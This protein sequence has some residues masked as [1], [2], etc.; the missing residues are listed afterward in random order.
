MNYRIIKYIVGWVLIFEAVFMAPAL[1]T[2]LIYQEKAGSS[3]MIA[4]GL[5]LIVGGLM[6]R[7]KTENKTMYAR[8]GFVTV[9]LC[10]IVLSIFGALPFVISGYIPSYIDAL[11][12]VVSGFTTTGS[13]IL[14]N[15][16]ALPNCL[17]FWRSFTHWI[18]GMGVLVF[19]MAILPLAGG[20]NMY[21]MKA[22]SPGPSV[23]KLV[24]KVKSTATILYGMYLI[25]SLAQ[26]ILLLLGRMPLFDALATM[27]GTAGTGGFGIKNDSMAG[28]STYIQAV[29][30]VFMIL[31]GVNFNV[32]YLFLKRKWGM[33]VK[34]AEVKAYFGII[35]V[36]IALITINISGM[37]PSVLE[38]L[39]HAAFQV[40]TIITTTGFMTTDFDLWPSFSKTILVM[41]MFI[42]ACAGSTGGGF[43]VSRI[44]I[45]FKSILKELDVIVHPHNVKK[46]KVDGR[47]VEHSV[48]RSVNVFLASYVMI[49]AVSL[50]L[51]SLDNFDFTTNFTAVAAT[52]NNI[53]PGLSMV[54]PTKNFAQ[55][56][57]FSKL[58]LTFDMLVGRLELFP[59]LILFSRN[60]WKR[61]QTEKESGR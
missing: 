58:V 28:Y 41:L 46:L 11:F 21:L 4:M 37:F 53:G 1:L 27:F 22:E 10:W 29:T 19:V 44:V 38:A 59:L 30:T 43:K 45:L 31:F 23:G 52:M 17:L 56:S 51:I 26:L 35:F 42:G 7:K 12:E 48:V 34:S 2:A 39:H 47:V 5:C 33:A 55:F 18:G 16:E 57:D 6:T 13:S 15:V 8:E 14:N 50:L 20:N 49:F 40:G 9:A 24:P 32:Y 3:L 25:L 61:G 60:T 54:G 36:S